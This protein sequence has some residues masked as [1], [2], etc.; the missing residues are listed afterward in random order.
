MNKSWVLLAVPGGVTI[1]V[2][3][4]VLA[5]LVVK[6]LWSWTVPDLCPG[7]VQQNLVS[8]TISWFTS[9]KLAIFVALLAAVSGVSRKG[10]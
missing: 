9:L 6:L 4:F 1:F 5:L 7:A 8:G 2:V 10:K 3:V